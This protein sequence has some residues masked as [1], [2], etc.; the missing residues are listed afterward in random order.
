MPPAQ[1]AGQAL[2]QC[3]AHATGQSIISKD[4]SAGLTTNGLT[5]SDQPP[6]VLAGSTRQTPYGRASYAQ[7]PSDDGEVWAV[8]YDKGSCLVFIWETSPEPV[9]KRLVEM[10][11]IPNAWEKQQAAAA[12]PGERKLEYGWQVRPDFNLTGLVSI[13]ELPEPMDGMVMVTISRTVED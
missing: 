3:V 13:R 8:G 5:Y 12:A 10:F 4:N 1:A 7:A 11:E 9:V 6:S 2:I